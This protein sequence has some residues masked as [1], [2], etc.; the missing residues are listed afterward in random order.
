[1]SEMSDNYTLLTRYLLG[2]LP[3]AEK[4]RLEENYF[5]DDDLFVELL[6]AKDQLI[7][8]YL[9]GQL[10]LGDRERF[11]RRFMT[12]PGC[13]SEVELAGFL[14][15]SVMRRPLTRPQKSRGQPRN[16][17]QTIFDALRP[18]QPLAG[19]AATAL[20]IVGA[21]AI[22]SAIRIS[23][24]EGRT[25]VGQTSSPTP[26]GP[27]IVSLTLMPGR[28]RAE[29]V[30]PK[31]VVG[32]GTQVIELRLEAGTENY[33]SYRASLRTDDNENAEIL[34]DS[35]LKAEVGADGRRTVIWKAPASG[36]FGD[37]QVKLSGV[38]ANNSLSNIGAYYFK[39]RNQ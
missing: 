12:V 22:W 13:Q 20:L 31:A 24:D 34:T 4:D 3:P 27:A 16:W 6:D 35:S 9:G 37:Y 11:E 7:S 33:L 2:D 21:A 14:Q 23:S 10:S 30:G 36:L 18:R 26:A 17:R 29:G 32:L 1:M 28:F 5:V 25:K 38:G 15:P 19:L 39:V 8:D